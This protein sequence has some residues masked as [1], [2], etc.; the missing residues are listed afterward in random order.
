[1]EEGVNMKVSLAVST[2][3]SAK[4][5]RPCIESLINAD[6]PDK[7][8]LVVDDGSTDK[9]LEI[10]RSYPQIKVL[11]QNHQGVSAGRDLALRNASGEIICYTDSDCEVDRNWIKEL[12]KPLDNPEVGAVTGR[13]DF[14]TDDRCTSWVRSLDIAERYDHRKTWTELANGTNCAFRRD[15]LISLGGF[16]P[17]WFHA[18]DTEV[19]YQLLKSGHRIYYQPTAKVRHVPEGDWKSYLRKR[20]RGT[21]AH[22]RMMPQYHTDVVKDDFVSLKMMVQPVLYTLM[23]GLLMVLPITLTCWLLGFS[24]CWI[25][26][27]WI[28]GVIIVLFSLGMMT[29]ISLISKV[30]SRSRKPSFLIKSLGLLSA[31]SVMIGWGVICGIWLNFI[32]RPKLQ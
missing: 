6:W 9:S 20:Y 5:L 22:L 24:G 3:N 10:L 11:P 4:T 21:K 19:S 16:D 23:T 27:G 31:K 13:T 30:V 28:N 14:R 25:L 12:I 15:L 32:R 29:E 26:S 1:M 18:E 17:K 8:I 7:E 2:Y